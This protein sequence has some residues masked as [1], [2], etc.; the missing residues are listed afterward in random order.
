MR[1]GLHHTLI[2]L[3]RAALL[4]SALVLSA[5]LGA[6]MASAPALAADKLPIS[7][8]YGEVE[9]KGCDSYKEETE[10]A[11]IVVDKDGRGYGSGGEC[12][13]KVK[14]VK[15]TGKKEYSVVTV[16]QCIDS[17][18]KETETTKL[19]ILSDSEIELDGTKYQK[20]KPL[21]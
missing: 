10:G 6:G 3:S 19:V 15:K 4:G 14:S 5:G 13:C 8:P 17:P 1:V 9:G 18:N 12:G 16:C 21:H 7:G 2:A 11:Y 20:C